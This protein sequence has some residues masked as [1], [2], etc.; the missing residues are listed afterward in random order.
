[1]LEHKELQR[2]KTP[3]TPSYILLLA[4]NKHRNSNTDVCAGARHASELYAADE[5]AHALVRRCNG[6][7]QAQR[8][9]G[10]RYSSNPVLLW[11]DTHGAK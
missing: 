9:M 4:F 10:C 2:K 1:M 3:K 6:H 5:H 8:G 7:P 11:P